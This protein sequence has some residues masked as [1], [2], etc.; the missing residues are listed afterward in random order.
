MCCLVCALSA[1]TLVYVCTDVLFG[2]CR[3]SCVRVY[4]CTVWFVQALL[5][6]CVQKWKHCDI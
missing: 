3:H 6:T 2:L 1:G 5:C 4:R